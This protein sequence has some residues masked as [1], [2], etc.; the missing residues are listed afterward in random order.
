MNDDNRNK[1]YSG[2]DDSSPGG[3]KGKS[4][5]GNSEGHAKAGRK[6]GKASR[7]TNNENDNRDSNSS[8][9]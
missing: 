7:N 4:W 2:G 1:N 6:G 3:N 9:M 5:H 8:A